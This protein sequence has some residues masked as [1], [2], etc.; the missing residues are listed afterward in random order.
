M[1]MNDNKSSYDNYDG[2][3]DADE[4]EGTPED[5]L[6]DAK[7][8]FQ[9]ICEA[10]ARNRSAW[11][12]DMRFARLGEQWPEEIRRQRELEGR[13]CLTINRLPAFIRQVTNDARQNSP[14][15]K[16]HPVGDGADEEVA[17]IL[18]GLIRNIEYSS[19]ADVAYDTALDHAVTGGFG[20]FRIV[21]EYAADDVFDQD[22]KIERISNPLTVYGDPY[23]TAADSSD[24]NECFITDLITRADFKKRYPKATATEF[25]ADQKD[26]DMHWFDDDR[27][28]IAEY[29]VRKDVPAQLLML[30]NG[31]TMFEPEYVRVKDLMDSQQITVIN[32]RTTTTKKV[33]QYIMSGAEI[34]ETNDWAGK[35]IP[36]VPVYGDEVDVEGER[37]FISLVRFAKDPARMMNFWRTASTELVALAPKTPFIGAAG[38]FVT[39]AEKWATANTQ[40]HAYIE[41][42]PVQGGSP[43]QRQQFAGPPA[44]A[45]QE[46]LNASDDMKSIMGIFDASLGARSNETSG[47][48]IM[49]RQREGDVST[50]N[51]I[52]NLSRAIRHA[53]RIIVDLIPKVYNTQRIVRVIHEDGQNKNVPINQPFQPTPDSENENEQQEEINGILKIYDL[54][55]GKYDVTC[56]AG[57]S[58]TTKREEASNQM[59][60]FI[61]AV[62]QATQFIGDLLAK[63]LDWPGADDI[64]KRLKLMLPPQVQGQNPQVQQ[65]QQQMQQMDG[66]ARQKIG[67]LT[68]QLQDSEKSKQVDL[69]KV[70]IDGY[71]AETERM[72]VLGVPP[73]QLQ[74]LLMQTVMQAMQSPDPSPMPPY[75]SMMQPQG[76]PPPGMQ[77]PMQPQQPMPQQMQPQQGMPPGQ[78]PGMPQ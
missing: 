53:G 37:H 63:N 33:T 41:Y 60:E 48:A 44:G 28:R 56:E 34:L 52:D 27:I 46:A 55:T 62:P 49:A 19:N 75:V 42:D 45:L 51:F 20:Y 76:G 10:E 29:W 74:A 25:K 66:Q 50:F 35:Y 61:R 13:P 58:F 31:S 24:W 15:I 71:K 54:T 4:K 11:L 3:D 7:E 64:A 47:R 77:P 70:Q 73:E 8:C 21:T 6:S 40:T 12:D 39:D 57:P 38:S 2:D 26:R 17:E 5:I 68:Q 43:P 72:K 9:K 16:C 65:M 32:T 67:E 14:S 1:D 18:N 69:I 78:P 36:I 23:S 30:S 22:I 59:L